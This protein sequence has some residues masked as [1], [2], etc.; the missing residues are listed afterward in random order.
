MQGKED[1]VRWFSELSSKDTLLVGEKAA[2]LAEIANA[3]L[4]VPVGFVVTSK[5]FEYFL[6]KTAIGKKINEILSDLNHENEENLRNKSY[7]VRE[8]IIN[9]EFPKELQSEILEAYEVLDVD[10]KTFNN[11]SGGA[12]DILRT[13]HEPPFVSI[14]SSPTSKTEASFAGQH[15]SFLNIKG[16]N[17]L[18]RRIKE[19]FAS[20]FSEKVLYYKKRKGVD[21][22]E[23]I[24]VI[25]QEM[26]DVQKSGVVFS[27][28][29]L[30]SG[31][32][33]IEAI[34]GFGVGLNSFTPDSYLLN[35]ALDI[36]DSKIT[37]K[38]AAIVRDSAG[39][40]G[41]IPLSEERGKQQVLTG[42]EIKKLAQ[43]ALQLEQHFKKPQDIEFAINPEGVYILQSRDITSKRVAFDEELTGNVLLSG[44]GV[45]HG[46]GSGNVKIV[47]NED[48][49]KKVQR[50]DVI[51]TK[52]LSQKMGLKMHKAAAMI[53]EE[54]GAS[55]NASILAREI[56]LP[57]V[58][59][60]VEA[61]G[62][63][64]DGQLVSVDAFTGRI[65]EGKGFEKKLEI[66]PV[67]PTRTKIRLN[68]DVPEYAEVAA[69][70]RLESIGLTRIECLT[71]I[72]GKHANWYIKNNETKSY[73]EHLHSNLKK[74]TYPFREAWFR[75]SDIKS[76]EYGNLVGASEQIESNPLL[77]N[78]GIRF[79]LRNIDLFETE[80]N[81]IKDL[82]D[83]FPERKFAVMLPQVISVE[84][85][86]ESKRIIG[87]VSL[88]ANVKLGVMIETPASVQ[89][90]EDI[91]REGVD[92]VNIGTDDLIQLTLAIDRNNPEVRELYNELHPAVL[93]SV[94]QVITKCK[95]FG[96]PVSICGKAVNS[97]AFARF[98]VKEGIDSLTVNADS[99]QA[100]SRVVAETERQK[101]EKVERSNPGYGI[102]RISEGIFSPEPILMQEVIAMANAP[103][104]SNIPNIPTM[105]MGTIK[106][107]EKKDIDEEELILKALEAE[108]EYLPGFNEK[109][110]DMPI[111][112]EAIPIESAQLHEVKKEEPH[113]MDFD[114]MDENDENK[115]EEVLEKEEKDQVL[116]IF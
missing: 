91:C 73:V 43:F 85:I 75:I 29:P 49:L 51:V 19:C 57:V 23:G 72:S 9:S 2:K 60:S 50:G 24:S 26:A 59:G 33:L 104:P 83:D 17:E 64:R 3:K 66:N 53:A 67:I 30:K 62:K 65:I 18:I 63:L 32:I 86:R 21:F 89:I 97:P 35:H 103:A 8:L 20:A 42:Y 54:G 116:D 48:D 68:V 27:D 39:R 28:N 7:E 4:P 93:N 100:I 94:K 88:P 101:S 82:A 76:D 107:D 74:I 40:V 13:S 44:T 105:E 90:I 52:N 12:L 84:E 37:I 34:W 22:H 10:R 87:K 78:H 1:Y 96:I 6:I 98:V 108:D 99:A 102:G 79:A 115:I 58:T 95:E 16:E 56:G 11:A 36:F 111:L 55:G 41:S 112:N 80:L 69:T 70:S 25:I 71:A 109:K 110:N 31:S 47:S 113:F 81:A 45:S 106:K 14:R 5:A 15:D 38:K 114:S 92:F 77:G 61:T 46:V